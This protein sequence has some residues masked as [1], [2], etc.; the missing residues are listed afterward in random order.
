MKIESRI[1]AFKKL[2][3]K[4]GRLT[5]E[6]FQQFEAQAFPHNRWFIKDSIAKAFKGLT[7]MLAD[8]KLDQWVESYQLQPEVPKIVGI[9]MAGNIPLVG[10][11]DLMSVLASGHVAAVKMSSQDEVLMKLVIDWLLE[12]EP[13]FKKSLQIRERLTDVDAVIAT[14]SDNTARYFEY[15]FGKIP[16]IIRKNRTSVAVLDGKETEEEIQKLGRDIYDYF[17]LGC[18][19]V[20]KLY[21]PENLDFT[22]LLDSWQD[23][24]HLLENSKY[25]NNYDYH[26]SIALV[27]GE[28]HLDTGFALFKPSQDLVS[29]TSVVYLEKYPDKDLVMNA[30][31]SNKSKIQCIIGH[32]EIRGAIPF[33]T[34]Q[35]PELW[36]YAD[37]VDTLSFLSSL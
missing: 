11:H 35:V 33:G 31:E 5:D 29:P 6:D 36:D 34:A 7:L 21:L 17:G 3:Q 12:I 24:S 1:E 27:N 22:H 14:G 13:R 32:K 25:K 10:F 2:G 23:Y 8:N 19:N 15:Y 30:L 37:G 28:D 16:H 18:R 4:F 20:S 26:K 9:V